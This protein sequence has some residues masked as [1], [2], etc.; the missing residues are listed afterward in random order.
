MLL[1]LAVAPARAQVTAIDRNAHYPEGPLWRAGKLLYVEY[2][3]GNIKSWDGKVASRIWHQDGC[4]PSGLIEH[5]RELLIAC[6]DGNYLAAI[7]S[8]GKQL[9][10]WR[11]DRYSIIVAY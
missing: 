10:Q 2:S 11:A 3:D 5:G 4:G 9:R 6:Y 8:S 1:A 7:D